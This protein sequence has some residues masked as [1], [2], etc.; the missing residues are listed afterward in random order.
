MRNAY[1]ILVR[2]PQRKR[3]LGR[4]RHKRK[5]NTKMG[6]TEIEWEG[7]DW[8][9]LVQDMDQWHAL[10][11]TVMNLWVPQKAGNFLAS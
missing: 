11:N 8:F 6:L 5:D 9:R 2:K 10:V 4:T 3:Y 7:V 1:K